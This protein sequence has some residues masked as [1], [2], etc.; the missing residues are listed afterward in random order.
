MEDLPKVIVLRIPE[1]WMP[2]SVVSYLQSVIYDLP[3]RAKNNYKEFADSARL[4]DLS[5][6]HMRPAPGKTYSDL[7]NGYNE[8]LREI[9]GLETNSET[10]EG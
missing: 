3:D 6:M 10:S 8:A 1:G 7:Q 2:D 5:S 9:A 4:I